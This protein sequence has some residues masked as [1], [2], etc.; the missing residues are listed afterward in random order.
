MGLVLVNKDKG[1]ICCVGVYCELGA[2]LLD[3]DLDLEVKSVKG[4]R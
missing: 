1:S 2:T 4:D 3:L